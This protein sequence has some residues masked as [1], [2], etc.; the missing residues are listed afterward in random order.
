MWPRGHAIG[1]WVT[2]ELRLRCRNTPC[3]VTA[4][5]P[6]VGGGLVSC[7]CLS[8]RVSLPGSHQLTDVILLAFSGADSVLGEEEWVGKAG[9]ITTGTFGGLLLGGPAE[10]S[11]W[12]GGSAK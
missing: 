9:G 11:W 12:W 1:G 8:R 6:K 2:N 4:G 10:R 7:R 5:N 3:P